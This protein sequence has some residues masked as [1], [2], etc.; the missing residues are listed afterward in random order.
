[1]ATSIYTTARDLLLASWK[2]S[3]VAAAAGIDSVVWEGRIL[4]G[5]RQGYIAEL[6]RGR[7]P[8]VE[9]FMAQNSDQW[10]EH[11]YNLGNVRAVWRA[12][13]HVADLT[14]DAA[15]EH[16]RQI[17]YAGLIALRANNY[18]HVGEDRVIGFNGSTLGHTLE[19][20]FDVDL[21][22][23]RETYGTT[24]ASSIGPVPDGGVVGGIRIA[25]NFDDTSPVSVL[26]LP[27]DQA[28]DS[29]QIHVVTAFDGTAP[30]CTIG[31]DGD[32][33]RYMGEDD[34]DL[35]D[36]DTKWEKDSDSPGPQTIKV[37]LDPD[38]S[39]Q[40]QIIVQIVTTANV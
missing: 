18:F 7:L 31:I 38:G 19:V 1:M 10:T 34:S 8:A 14:Q 11:A 2:G 13:I 3:P 39:A 21:V 40:G 29:V 12:R 30:V 15:E 6:H 23:S 32:Q 16:S 9:L 36:A 4:L 5:D 20:E 22:Q 24:P 25:I 27:A 28:V 37:W 35:T 33:G 26:A 17:M